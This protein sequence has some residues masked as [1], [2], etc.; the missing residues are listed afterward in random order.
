MGGPIDLTPFGAVLNGMGALY[1]LLV[2]AALGLALWRIKGE[3]PKLLAC[4]AILT[5]TDPM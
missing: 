2:L 5:V 3:V 4:T 1:W